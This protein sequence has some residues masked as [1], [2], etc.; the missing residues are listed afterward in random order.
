MRKTRKE[1]AK[2]KSSIKRI[3][4]LILCLLMILTSAGLCF[5][6]APTYEILNY[7]IVASV[8]DDG[9]VNLGYHIDWKVLVDNNGTWPLEDVNVGIPNNRYITYTPL[10]DNIKNMSYDS[11]YGCVKVEFYDKYYAGDTVSFEFMVVQDYMYEM[12][13]LEDGYTLYYFVPGWFDEIAVDN[14]VIYWKSD[15]LSSWSGGGYIEDGYNVWQ[16]SLKPGERFELKV[17]YPNDAYMFDETKSYNDP[18]ED[19]YH[20]PGYSASDFLFGLFGFFLFIV[21]PFVAIAKAIKKSYDRSSGF[22]SGDTSTKVT[23]TKIEYYPNCPG[24]GAVRKEGQ[25]VC[26]YCGRSLVK[27]EEIIKEEEVKDEDKAALKYKKNGEYHYGSDPNTYVRVNV[28]HVP[29]SSS[30]RSSSSRSSGSSRPRGGG[31]GGSSCAHSSCAC[32]CASCACACACACAG[33]GRAGCST[34]DFYNTKLK[35]KQL[36]MKKKK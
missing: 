18:Y 26:E 9:T 2:M 24:C 15:K 32:A 17:S 1:A 8:N 25:T 27:S 13:A 19:D 5:A 29:V 6:D 20:Y 23:R 21:L 4:A 36:E 22:A 14:L 31:G 10:T 34:K 11:S 7:V 3:S 33:G 16:T 12:N 30:S 28:I 35:L